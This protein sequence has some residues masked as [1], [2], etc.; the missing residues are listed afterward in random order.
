MPIY[1][2]YCVDCH[3]VF[4]F[5]SRTINTAK[6]P[7]CP[8]CGRPDLERRVSRFAISKG[9]T[10]RGSPEEETPDLDETK[11]ERVMEELAREG[12]GLDE[13]DPR[14]MARMMRKLHENSGMPLDGKAEEAIRRMEAGESPDKIEEAMGDLLEGDESSPGNSGSLSGLVRKLRPPGIDETLYDL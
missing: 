10:E 5:F 6:R 4:N 3:T 11:M 7:A 2:F 8:R 9:R 1:E 12:E 14:Q 13:N